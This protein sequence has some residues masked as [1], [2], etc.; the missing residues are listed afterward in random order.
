MS[1]Q[2]KDHELD[3]E[4]T[5]E[6]TEEEYVVLPEGEYSF[7]VLSFTRG[8]FDGSEKMPACNKAIIKLRVADEKGS[9]TTIEHTLLLH[10]KTE[11]ALSQFFISIGQMQ[12]GEKL[13]MKWNEVPTA[14]GRCK[15]I[16]NT[17]TGKDGEERN[18][19]RISKF[20]PPEEVSAPASSGGF[21][22]GK[23]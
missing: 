21:T 12:K 5:I 8:R 13:K 1:E 20:L 16:V 18:G 19:N 14:Q 17:W 2:V 4:D 6:A 22:A 3:W 11:W 7:V 9:T 23:F 15:V 10:S